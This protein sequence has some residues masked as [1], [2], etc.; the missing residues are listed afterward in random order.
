MSL[1]S[2]SDLGLP[3]N[4]YANI[5]QQ[6]S[7]ATVAANIIEIGS[8]KNSKLS[9]ENTNQNICMIKTVLDIGGNDS[10]KVLEKMKD[11]FEQNG[12]LLG[13]DSDTGIK[14]PSL[15]PSNLPKAKQLE[16]YNSCFMNT[17]QL[18]EI[19]LSKFSLTGASIKQVNE[20]FSKCLIDSG[21][22][23]K[24][25]PAPKLKPT[26]APTEATTEA[27]TEAPTERPTERPSRI[28]QKSNNKFLIGG[29]VGSFLLFCCFF[30]VCIIIVLLVVTMKK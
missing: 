6:C 1:L 5:Y 20:A 16:I 14:D 12:K 27:T 17:N 29:T 9:Q 23:I 4:T 22:I 7:V 18:N 25:T 30:C 10:E 3:A 21:A 26:K 24:T 2:A 11:D 8:L 13:T 28:V 19:S 15:I